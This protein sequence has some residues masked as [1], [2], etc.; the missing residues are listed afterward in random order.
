VKISDDPAVKK[1]VDIVTTE[2]NYNLRRA[3]SRG[4]RTPRIHAFARR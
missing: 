1:L 2:T 4:S 3:R